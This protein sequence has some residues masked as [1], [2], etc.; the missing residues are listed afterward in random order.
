MSLRLVTDHLHHNTTI[1]PISR[2]LITG[3]HQPTM[4][5]LQ[6]AMVHL[7]LTMVHLQQTMAHHHLDHSC[8]QS[9]ISAET[10]LR[11]LSPPPRSIRAADTRD[12]L[13]RQFKLMVPLHILDP[14]SPTPTFDVMAGSRFLDLPFNPERDMECLLLPDL[15]ITGTGTSADKISLKRSVIS[16]FSMDQEMI[17]K[18][19]SSICLNWKFLNRSKWN[20]T[21]SP[22]VA[23]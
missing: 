6:L 5:H 10:S 18:E 9:R 3:H 19:Q 21:A 1:S 23:V 12:R 13:Q 20:L 8:R 17:S 4:V 7:Q 22:T 11:D 14:I 15:V 16:T 2:N